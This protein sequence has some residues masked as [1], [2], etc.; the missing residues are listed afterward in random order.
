MTGYASAS[1]SWLGTEVNQ[2]STAGNY[3][4]AVQ[5]TAST[6]LSNATGVNL[7][8]ELSN[9]LALEQSYQASAK[10][11]NTVNTLYTALFSSVQ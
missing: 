5:N 8:T 6:A 10:L 3:S 7:D 9:M 4:A 11:L 2:A 1:A